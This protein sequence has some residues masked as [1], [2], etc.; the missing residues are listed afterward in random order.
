MHAC[1]HIISYHMLA[2]HIIYYQIVSYHIISYDII[3]YA[4]EA[5]KIIN[6][7]KSAMWKGKAAVL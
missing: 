4:A 1:M 7:F 3:S 6:G 2:C 5:E